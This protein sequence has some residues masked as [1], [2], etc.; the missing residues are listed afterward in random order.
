MAMTILQSVKSSKLLKAKIRELK[1]NLLKAL[2]VSFI[3]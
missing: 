1:E 3:I 2:K